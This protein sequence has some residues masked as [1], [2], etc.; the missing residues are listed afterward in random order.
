MGILDKR[1]RELRRALKYKAI[2]K[3]NTKAKKSVQKNISYEFNKLINETETDR[4]VAQHQASLKQNIQRVLKQRQTDLQTL[5]NTDLKTRMATLDKNIVE[6]ESQK[7][8]EYNKVLE[9]LKKSHSKY[10]RFFK[11]YEKKHGWKKTTQKLQTLNLMNKYT[12]YYNT[13]KKI[14]PRF[15]IPKNTENQNYRKSRSR[16]VLTNTEKEDLDALIKEYDNTLKHIDKIKQPKKPKMT[17]PAPPIDKE[18]EREFLDREKIITDK[19]KSQAASYIRYRLLRVGYSD[20][21]IQQLLRKL[22]PQEIYDISMRFQ[23]EVPIDEDSVIT[24][25][26]TDKPEDLSIVMQDILSEEHRLINRI[27]QEYELFI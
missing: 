5:A 24:T 19:M 9:A 17:A 1:K 18:I 20:F 11:N 2:K 25:P 7:K 3:Q 26:D 4:I 15:Q 27:I 16:S 14:R 23:H 10:Y 12:D 13:K 21:L 22:E 8:S 6:Y